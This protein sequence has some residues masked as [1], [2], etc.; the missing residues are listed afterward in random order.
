M[1]SSCSTD[2]DIYAD[3]KDISIVY[4]LMDSS[5]DTSWIKVTKAFSGPGNALL[6]ATN[7]DSSSY[8]YKLDVRL[9]GVQNGI[10][11]QNIIFDTITITNKLAG[12]S[13]FYYP[14]QLVYYSIEELNSDYNYTL[15]IEKQDGEIIAQTGVVN[16]FYVTSPNRYIN[17]M[18]DKDIKWNSA[19]NG[20]RY[21][22]SLVFN[23]LELRPGN[24]DTLR[25]SMYWYLGTRKSST[26]KGGENM[27]TAYVGDVFYSKLENE[28][29]VI[30]GVKRWSA[31]VDVI[32]ACASQEFDTYLE[33][34][35][36]S[37]SLLTE[38]PIYTNID[39]GTGLFASRKT[40]SNTTQLSVQSEL[41]LVNS[42]PELGF[43]SKNK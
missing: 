29:E 16:E 31:G 2:V 35:E 12:D 38:V 39:G 14:N 23:Y 7:A 10:E 37:G 15:T 24:T 25:K 32:I 5:D 40:I 1:F 6:F 36:G 43:L 33:V 17:F 4:G 34:N 42:Y 30:S 19:E 11:K 26:V 20:K 21:E 28:L 9:T 27:Y 13:V 22:V 41:K 8:P 18:L 3:Y